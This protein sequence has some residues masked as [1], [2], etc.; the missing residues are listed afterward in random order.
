MPTDIKI[1]TE[2][3]YKGA[4]VFALMDAVYVPL[5]L[6]RVETKIFRRMRWFLVIAA[7]GVSL[8]AKSRARTGISPDTTRGADP[9]APP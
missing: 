3:L 7:A 2:L 1:T 6:W 5:L 8:R 9:P 4:L